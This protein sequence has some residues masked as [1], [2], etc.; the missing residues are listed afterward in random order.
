MTY[1][2]SNIKAVYNITH[3]QPS[4]VEFSELFFELENHHKENATQYDS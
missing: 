2:Y 1:T 3:Q 4:I